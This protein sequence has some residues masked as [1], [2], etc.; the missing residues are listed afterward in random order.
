MTEEGGRGMEM[1]VFDG[2]KRGMPAKEQRPPAKEYPAPLFNH[3][4][5][6]GDPGIFVEALRRFHS[7]MGTKFMIP[8]IGGK[9]L[10]LHLLYVEVTRRGGLE[11]VIVEKRWREVISIFNFPAT[12]TS[13][14][15]V[16]RKYY[17]SLLHHFEQ[18]YFFGARGRLVPPAAA[19]QTRNQLC[20]FDDVE[21]MRKK[22]RA[23]PPAIL[24]GSS[25]LTDVKFT[26][27]IQNGHFYAAESSLLPVKDQPQ[28]CKPAAAEERSPL[29]ADEFGGSNPV[30]SSYKPTSVPQSAPP[31]ASSF[32]P[33]AGESLPAAAGGSCNFTVTGTIDGKFDY[34]YFVTVKIGSQLLHGI[35]YHI[36]QHQIGI[37]PNSSSALAN[38]IYRTPTPSSFAPVATETAGVPYIPSIRSGGRRRR[39]K[40]RDPARPKPNRSSYNFFFAEKHCELKAQCPQME[41]LYS[42]KIGE[43]WSKLADEDRQVYEEHAK[44]D[45]E[46]YRRELL[47]YKEKIK[48][49]EAKQSDETG[50]GIEIVSKEAEG[51]EIHDFCERIETTASDMQREE[52]AGKMMHDCSKRVECETTEEPCHDS[53]KEFMNSSME[54]NRA[55]PTDVNSGS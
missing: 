15:F 49:A 48:F 21:R 5:L 10:S 11:K 51:R 41:R 9:D 40:N 35:L 22:K 42:K 52:I 34:G 8:V 30:A 7:L 31:T 24:P 54:I 13:A 44:R 39:P 55:D 16:L 18:V 20:K 4:Q 37:P 47:V 43:S 23:F 45:K 25:S 3:N 27:Q 33:P 53:G 19:L 6:C 26:T 14:S 46:R 38:P 12:T 2:K 29:S 1:V 32:I 28:H 17:L 36:H 50:R